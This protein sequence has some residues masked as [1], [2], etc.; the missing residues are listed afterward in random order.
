ME[1]PSTTTT[2]I[3]IMKSCFGGIRVYLLKPDLVLSNGIYGTNI[4]IKIFKERNVFLPCSLA[5]DICFYGSCVANQ[6]IY[7]TCKE[8][9]VLMQRK[10]KLMEISKNYN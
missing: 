7:E 9:V 10:I 8:D 3:E 2:A 4:C 1:I 5:E 6:I